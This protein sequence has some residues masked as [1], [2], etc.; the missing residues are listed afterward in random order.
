MDVVKFRSV[1]CVRC[2]VTL[3]KIWA[4]KNKI[5]APVKTGERI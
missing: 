4:T 5:N 3:L 2:D 1:G